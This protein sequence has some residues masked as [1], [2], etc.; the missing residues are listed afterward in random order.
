MH[1]ACACACPTAAGVVQ[2]V[3]GRPGSVW[4]GTPVAGTHLPNRAARAHAVACDNH[5][6]ACDNHVTPVE[7]TGRCEACGRR[8]GEGERRVYPGTFPLIG[9]CPWRKPHAR[10]TSRRNGASHWGVAMGRRIG[11]SHW[12][13]AL[14]RR[15]GASHW[16]VALGVRAR[17]S[18]PDTMTGA[19]ERSWTGMMLCTVL[20]GHVCVCACVRVCVCACVRVC[21]FGRVLRLGWCGVPS[22]CR[23]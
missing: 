3:D 16:G 15:I 21:V 6:S 8:L 2:R 14:G 19:Q 10:C 23:A 1:C 17:P 13:V 22:A 12:G 11:A 4:G 9:S 7:A 5:V 20:T 18:G